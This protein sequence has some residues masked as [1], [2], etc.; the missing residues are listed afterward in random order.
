MDTILDALLNVLLVAFNGILALATVRLMWANQDSANIARQS[1]E[2]AKAA[3]DAAVRHVV[4][5]ERQFARTD[6]PY[7]FPTNFRIETGPR[8][9]V[10]IAFDVRDVAGVPAYVEQVG[11]RTWFGTAEERP[12]TDLVDHTVAMDVYKECFETVSVQFH[13]PGGEIHE[14]AELT[15][16]VVIIYIDHS[17]GRRE[18]WHGAVS[19]VYQDGRLQSRLFMGGRKRDDDDE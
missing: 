14:G 1:A 5:V 4:A 18:I 9:P 13:P 3:A 7:V 11:T 12:R 17:T 2:A 6:R 10:F 8:V 19:L 15:M 16:D